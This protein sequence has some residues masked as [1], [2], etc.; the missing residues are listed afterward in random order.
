[1]T[2]S[3]FFQCKGNLMSNTRVKTIE[4]CETDMC[5]KDLKPTYE[6]PSTTEESVTI[7]P[8]ALPYIVLLTS[9]TIC[10]IVFLLVIAFVYLRYRRKEDLRKQQF[11]G[12][13]YPDKYNLVDQSSGSG[14]GCPKLVQR[15]I[16]KQ[17]HMVKSV[18]KG[19]YG[20]V[21]LAR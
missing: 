1:M 21:W 17:L 11:Y 13:R 3:S 6:I 2:L 16:S 8:E 7:P 12:K 18:G 20:E 14:S 10:V 9:V 5:N 19:R 4:C 15:T